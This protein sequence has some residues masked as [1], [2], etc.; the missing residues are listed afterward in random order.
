M[1]IG[2]LFDNMSAAPV[3]PA[4]SSH[5]V[6]AP[7]GTVASRSIQPCSVINSRHVR[8]SFQIGGGVCAHVV[9]WKRRPC[10][11]GSSRT[12]ASAGSP[13]GGGRRSKQSGGCSALPI[14]SQNWRSN[15]RQFFFLPADPCFFT[16]KKGCLKLLFRQPLLLTEFL[17]LPD[18][19]AAFAQLITP[20]G[21][22][23][24]FNDQAFY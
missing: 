22:L 15:N 21:C 19:Q 24:L 12:G 10:L 20:S 23:S 17:N 4:P 1:D 6:H 8:G 3:R 5:S 11:D 18:R 7:R 9:A 14:T 2:P 16:T 13:S